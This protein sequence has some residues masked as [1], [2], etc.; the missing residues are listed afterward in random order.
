MA[1]NAELETRV[2]ELESAVEELAAE[3]KR[4]GTPDG[5]VP[6]IDPEVSDG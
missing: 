2:E 3:V 6:L 4:I 1:T 5:Y